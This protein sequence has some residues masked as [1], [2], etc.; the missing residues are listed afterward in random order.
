[1]LFFVFRE[2]KVVL[3]GDDLS[4]IRELEKQATSFD[5]PTY[6]VHD[7]GRTEVPSD[8]LTVLAL[9]GREEQVNAITGNLSLL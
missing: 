8:S 4:H 6:L 5:V 2:K 3:R 7:A 9:F 1:M